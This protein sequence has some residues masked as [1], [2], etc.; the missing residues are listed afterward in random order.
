MQYGFVLPF[1]DPKI[2]V[3]LGPEVERAGWD[4]VFVAEMIWGPDAWVALSG[5]AVQTGRIKLGTMLSPISRMRPWKIASEA[6][7]LDQLSG[8]RVILAVGLGALDT[9]FAEFGEVT[10][11][12]IRNELIDESLE[13]MQRLWT[14][15]PFQF[16]G[17]HYQIDTLSL[18]AEIQAWGVRPVQQPRIPIWLTGVWPPKKSMHRA[19]R[20]DGILP[21][22]INQDGSFGD[23]SV[24]AIAGMRAFVEDANLDHPVAIV[25]EGNT[26]S[27]SAEEITRVEAWREAGGTWWIESPWDHM[28]D[29]DRV[30]ARIK[31]GPPRIATNG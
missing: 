17:K 12:A 27:N 20:F 2:L 8:G 22:Y 31:L 24:E 7:T 19:L 16:R 25:L 14:G 3:E 28:N 10:D 30:L 11:R 5:I 18:S 15:E 9:G 13:I 23:H 4:G 6:A 1:T 21:N 26:A 29:L